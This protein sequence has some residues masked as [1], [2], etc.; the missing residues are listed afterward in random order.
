MHASL[1]VP[2]SRASLSLFSR[3]PLP[4]QLWQRSSAQVTAV[5]YPKRWRRSPPLHQIRREGTW[6]HRWATQVVATKSSP[7]LD[8]AGGEV[9]AVAASS[10]PLDPVG[11][12]RQASTTVAATPSLTSAHSLCS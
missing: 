2:L 4:T 10:P 5:G 9:A 8:L 11:G 6:R 7:P 1:S 3:A 12:R